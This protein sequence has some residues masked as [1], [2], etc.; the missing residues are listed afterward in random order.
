MTIEI[1]QRDVV[2]STLLDTESETART[3][4]QDYRGPVGAAAQRDA[5]RGGRIGRHALAGISSVPAGL[6]MPLR[7]SR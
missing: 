2:E 7:N 3:R 5:T 6:G 4:A 1:Q